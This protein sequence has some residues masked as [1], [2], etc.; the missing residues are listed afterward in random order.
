MS[1]ENFLRLPQVMSRTGMGRSYI[2][3]KIREGSFPTPIPL[4]RRASVWLKSEVEAWIE[5]RVV[6]HRASARSHGEA[7]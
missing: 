5:E 2:Y 6:E 7:A 3:Q 1:S 4:G